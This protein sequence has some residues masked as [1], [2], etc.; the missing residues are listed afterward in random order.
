MF[1]SIL[2]FCS[3][4]ICIMTPPKGEQRVELL[5]KEN[6]WFWDG[7]MRREKGD[8]SVGEGSRN[9]GEER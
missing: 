4:K 2:V 6:V 3:Q 7:R 1:R 9:G 8:E 5:P